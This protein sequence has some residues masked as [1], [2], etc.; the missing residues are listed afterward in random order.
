MTIGKYPPR[1]GGGSAVF[2]DTDPPLIATEGQTV[3]TADFNIER[4][5]VDSILFTTGYS[6]R[7]TKTITFDVG[8]TDGQE[9]YLTT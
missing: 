8:R 4:V 1:G 5:F 3:F 6:G 9:I 7:G 2:K